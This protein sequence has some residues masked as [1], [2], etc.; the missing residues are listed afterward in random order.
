MKPWPP[1]RA[2]K[3]NN[4]PNSLVYKIKLLPKPLMGPVKVEIKTQLKKERKKDSGLTP[5]SSDS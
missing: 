2:A 4:F 1:L 5:N 3:K